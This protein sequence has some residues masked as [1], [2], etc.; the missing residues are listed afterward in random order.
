MV[1][2]REPR[3]ARP[4][5]READ[6]AE[7]RPETEGAGERAGEGEAPPVGP[8]ERH[9]EVREALVFLRAAGDARREGERE[10]AN[11]DDDD[12]SND[13]ELVRRLACRPATP[14]ILLRHHCCL[15]EREATLRGE[16]IT[17]SG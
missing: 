1:P 16:K 8:G 11:S 6:L 2:S 17:L 4:G 3:E 15:G 13:A 14:N 5:E 9:R 12:D 10:A 7:A